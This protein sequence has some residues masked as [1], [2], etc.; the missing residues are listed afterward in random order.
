MRV[1]LVHQIVAKALEDLKT[2]F[3]ELKSKLDDIE[4]TNEIA[5]SSMI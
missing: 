5:Y 3:V 1:I 2:L 4:Y